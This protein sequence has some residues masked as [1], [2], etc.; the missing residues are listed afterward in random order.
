[1]LPNIQYPPAKRLRRS[2]GALAKAEVLYGGQVQQGM[3][4]DDVFGLC[5]MTAPNFTKVNT[6]FS[7]YI[8]YW[9]LDIR[10]SILRE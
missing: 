2:F 8:R 10:H 1:M 5:K 3:S 6:L 7:F 9:I 4:N